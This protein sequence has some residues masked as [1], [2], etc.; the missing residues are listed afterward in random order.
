M[1]SNLKKKIEWLEAG[2]EKG[3]NEWLTEEYRK[4]RK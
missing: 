4:K 3:L 2:L 1:K